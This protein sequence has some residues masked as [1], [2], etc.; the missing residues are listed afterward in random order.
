MVFTRHESRVTSH[1]F[2]RYA[3]STSR[4]R[5]TRRWVSRLSISCS[6]SSGPSSQ[7]AKSAALAGRFLA[8][9][10]DGEKSDSALAREAVEQVRAPAVR[11]DTSVYA[12]L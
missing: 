3:F 1:G 7:G 4:A 8:S 5:S 2:F 9:R 10:P 11:T 6:C 12:Q